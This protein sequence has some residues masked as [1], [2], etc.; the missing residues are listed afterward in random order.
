MTANHRV[1]CWASG[2][3][4]LFDMRNTLCSAEPVPV[5]YRVLVWTSDYEWWCVMRSKLLWITVRY[6][7]P[8]V[9]NHYALCLDSGCKSCQWS[10]TM[11]SYTEQWWWIM[12]CFAEPSAVIHCELWWGSGCKSR[13]ICWA[14]DCESIGGMLSRGLQIMVW[15]AVPVDVNHGVLCWGSGYESWWAML[16]KCLWI[17]LCYAESMV[18]NYVVSSWASG[19]ESWWAM[20]S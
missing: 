13:E 6:D 12:W 9:M 4:T 2:C 18:M 20:L 16:S 1:L 14:S 8:F 5:N 11:V 10:W 7:E 3:E 15:Y 19:C 17:M